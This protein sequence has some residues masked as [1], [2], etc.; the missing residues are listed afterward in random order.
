[1]K[2]PFL[3]VAALLAAAPAPHATPRSRTFRL[4]CR[5][6]VPTPPAG[7]R[8]LEFWMPVPHDDPSQQVRELVI[9]TSVPGRQAAGQ[10]PAAPNYSLETDA[11][12]NRIL[13]VVVPAQK[14][15]KPGM[16]FNLDNM[17]QQ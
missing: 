11:Y 8:A 10:S 7:T 2:I 12:G 1:M 13:H 15:L 9:T 6:T 16:T 17:K 5:A 14:D 3:A 4:A